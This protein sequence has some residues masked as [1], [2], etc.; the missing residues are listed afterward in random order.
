ME[1]EKG[2][3]ILK[4]RE[5]ND[6]RRRGWKRGREKLRIERL[7]YFLQH[8]KRVTPLEVVFEQAK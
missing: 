8:T 4:G 3:Y 1:V 6:I 2:R 5:Q 7:L